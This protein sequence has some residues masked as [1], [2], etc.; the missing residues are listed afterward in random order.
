MSTTR[1]LIA[2]A[3]TL[4]DIDE[5]V[6][7][8]P[9][10]AATDVRELCAR[11]M[12]EPD[13]GEVKNL[14][15]AA[16][17]LMFDAGKLLGRRDAGADREVEDA[18]SARTALLDY[19]R[20]V[21]TERDALLADNERLSGLYEQAVKGRADMRSALRD[22]RAAAPQ[23]VSAAEVPMPEPDGEL[24][25][26]GEGFVTLS[27]TLFDYGGQIY[28]TE[29]LRTYGDDREAAGYARGLAKAEETLRLYNELLYQIEAKNPGETRHETALVYIRMAEKYLRNQNAQEVKP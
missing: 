10:Q 25:P 17:N 20:G 4:A 18:R 29:T 13:I 14:V 16:C 27:N 3:L 6:A 5:H 2:A 7:E 22:A 1:D 11:A 12:V 21:M 26:D 15:S 24:E 8:M 9:T 28:T 23:P 19:V